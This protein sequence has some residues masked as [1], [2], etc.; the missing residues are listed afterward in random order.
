VGI[1][2]TSGLVDVTRRYQTEDV[3]AGRGTLQGNPY[4]RKI[5]GSWHFDEAQVDAWGAERGTGKPP[6][7]TISL[8]EARRRKIIADTELSR[9]ELR[10]LK[11]EYIPEAQVT[12]VWCRLV[13][14]FKARILTMPSKLAPLLVS[15]SEP[16]VIRAMLQDEVYEALAELRQKGTSARS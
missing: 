3:A 7:G 4:C 14:N 5:D 9:Y 13:A 8:T 15:I 10:K 2:R 6:P 1:A 12:E 11:R 16:N